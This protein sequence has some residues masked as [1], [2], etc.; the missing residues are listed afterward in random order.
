[1]GLAEFF[2]WLDTTPGSTA[3][4]ESLYG[5]SLIEATHVL[6]IMLFVGTIMMVDLRILG[7]SFKETPI[8]QMLAKILPWT[9]AG[10]VVM[11][12]TGLLLV[13]A[14]PART[15]HSVWF[16]A[17]VILLVVGLINIWLFHRKVHK[18]PL[19]FEGPVAPA[20]ARVTAG[21]SLTV[22]LSIIVLG[23][24]IAYNWFDCDKPQSAFVRAVASCHAYVAV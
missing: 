1:L 16:R 15:Y 2:R 11:V 14:I 13:Y 4:H 23:R 3:L 19:A 20:A 5:Y 6:T 21:V 8:S 7:V 22:W 12:I 10:F 18:D 17:K 9:I 24:M